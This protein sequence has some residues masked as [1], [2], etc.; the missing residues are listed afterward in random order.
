MCHTN[1]GIH[2]NQ[3]HQNI[4]DF[5]IKT[6]LS[7]VEGLKR[8][9][10][11]LFAFL[12][13]SQFFIILNGINPS[14]RSATSFLPNI[15]FISP[16][17]RRYLDV[18]KATNNQDSTANNDNGGGNSIRTPATKKFTSGDRRPPN[19]RNKKTEYESTNKWYTQHRESDQARQPWR[20]TR[21]YYLLRRRHSVVAAAAK[22]GGPAAQHGAAPGFL[23]CG[24]DVPNVTCFI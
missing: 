3:K 14:I 15:A 7:T 13:L 23:N 17:K 18:E 16:A 21:I 6:I 10:H 19:Q 22:F 11:L 20:P 5:Q 9:I 8:Y 4:F 24:T 12:N 1:I 2:I